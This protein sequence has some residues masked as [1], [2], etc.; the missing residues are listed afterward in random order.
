M[1]GE[2][3]GRHSRRISRAIF[4]CTH[5]FLVA[6][7]LAACE[8]VAQAQFLAVVSDSSLDRLL[9]RCGEEVRR[10]QNV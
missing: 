3:D 4:P 1:V 2:T 10:M 9:V 6:V 8:K 7:F 5:G